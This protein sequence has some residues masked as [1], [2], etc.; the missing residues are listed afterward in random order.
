MWTLGSTFPCWV[1]FNAMSALQIHFTFWIVNSKSRHKNRSNWITTCVDM[2][3]LATPIIII[4]L[5]FRFMSSLPSSQVPCD[6]L[7]QMSLGKWE[8][9]PKNKRSPFFKNFSDP[10]EGPLDTAANEVAVGSELVEEQDDGVLLLLES[11]IR[12]RSQQR[13]E[14]H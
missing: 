14:Q 11:R 10:G 9:S 8:L 1:R 12:L 7:Q 2:F 5:L 3:N 13:R 4:N 6:C